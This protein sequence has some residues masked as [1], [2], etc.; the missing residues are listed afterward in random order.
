MDVWCFCVCVCLCAFF[1]VCVHVGALRRAH[2]QSKESY[3]IS[4]I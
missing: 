4:K 2:H 1:R 3:R